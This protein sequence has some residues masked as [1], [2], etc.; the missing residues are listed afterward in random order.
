MCTPGLKDFR[1]HDSGHK[2]QAT[3]HRI[4]LTLGYNHTNSFRDIWYTWDTV[5]RTQDSGH[6]TQD[7]R[8]RTQGSG[9]N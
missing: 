8:L 5:L 3:R 4:Q 1:L 7:T 9:Y 6:K 2:T